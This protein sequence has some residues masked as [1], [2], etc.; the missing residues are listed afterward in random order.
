MG[1]L[2]GVKSIQIDAVEVPLY[3]M[4]HVF[5]IS[6]AKG[7][8]HKAL[9]QGDAVKSRREPPVM[10]QELS[11]KRRQLLES[12]CTSM[13]IRG[14]HRK[15]LNCT[16]MQMLRAMGLKKPGLVGG[17]KIQAQTKPIFKHTPLGLVSPKGVLT[18]KTAS[19]QEDV[20]SLCQALVR[21]WMMLVCAAHG[22][23]D[24]MEARVE[25]RLAR[26]PLHGLSPKGVRVLSTIVWISELLGK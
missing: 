12:G 18:K 26:S 21:S 7:Q 5:G 23:V 24:V 25:G 4:E 11:A 6:N 8:M 16:V 10:R 17:Q 1:V 22:A 20:T 2:L 13:K 9:G 3:L 14:A 15:G 19:C